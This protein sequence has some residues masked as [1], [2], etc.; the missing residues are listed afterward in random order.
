MDI[1]YVLDNELDN[2]VEYTCDIL[3]K[4]DLF[5]QLMAIGF[6]IDSN[7]GIKKNESNDSYWN[8]RK[9]N[10]QEYYG[11]YSLPDFFNIDLSGY[12]DHG[13]FTISISLG[14]IVNEKKSFNY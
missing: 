13:V 1:R 6:E 7:W 11:N 14:N 5:E 9:E 4:Y 8:F 12:N 10:L 2:V 3:K